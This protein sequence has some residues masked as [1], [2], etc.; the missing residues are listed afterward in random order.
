M[1][2][3]TYATTLSL[4]LGWTNVAARP[5]SEQ[6]NAATP[7]IAGGNQTAAEAAAAKSHALEADILGLNAFLGGDDLNSINNVNPDPK[8]RIYPKR[9][10][11]DA[12]YSLSEQEL[13]SKIFIPKTFSASSKK[14]PVILVPGT[15]AMAG[16]TYRAN[17][18]PLL[19]KSDFADPL[20]V[21][22]PGASLGDA[23]GNAEYVAYAV[24]YVRSATGKRPAVVAW[25]QGN[26]N[27]Q[28]ALKYWPSTREAV[29]DLVAMS[30]DFH[31]TTEAFIAC[32]TGPAAAA[33]GC[34]PSVYQQGYDSQFVRTLRANGGDSAYVPTT[35]IF[36]ATDQIVQ[37][38][39][40][41]GASAFLKDGKDGA[42]A[43][44]VEVQ[45]VCPPGTPAGGTVTHEGMLYNAVAFALL[46]DALANEA[47]P[48]RLEKVDKKKACADPAAGDMDALSIQATKAVLADAAKNVLVYPNKVKREPAIRDYA[49]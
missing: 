14:Q 37:P 15:A 9:S 4:A 46:R 31:G 45:T 47:G 19:A 23:Q 44:N 7:S 22:I 48:G 32:G 33:V 34:T 10:E 43:S 25:S 6:Q 39:S 29:T 40:G 36:S 16:S 38:Q 18:A 13:R 42:K 35:S 1:K 17:L 21:N 8:D 2:T 49:R 28:W 30:P 12:P 41:P 24:N 3:T 11:K 27:A 5:V 20:W 26:L